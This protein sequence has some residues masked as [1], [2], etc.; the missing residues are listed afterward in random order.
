MNRV[1]PK[2]DI[3]YLDFSLINKAKRMAVSRNEQHIWK[4]MSEEELLR[5]TNLI[6][7][8]SETNQ[9][10]VTLAV[11]LLFGKDNTIMSVLPQHKTDS[12]FRVEN[13][14]R[15]DDRDVVIMNLIESYDR[16]LKFGQ[17]H[18]N[19]LFVLISFLPQLA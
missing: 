13:I 11:I 1:F 5:S 19:D 9:G 8:D 4:D 16:L 15:Y 2:L 7:I 14:D 18:L 3:N 17:K 12:I 10:G 6:L